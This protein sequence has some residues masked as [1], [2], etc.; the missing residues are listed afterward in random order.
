M[1]APDRSRVT[2]TPRT[3]TLR[4]KH[5]STTVL[6][7]VEPLQKLPEVKTELLI[8]L[9]ETHPSGQ[10]NGYTIPKNVDYVQLGRAVDRNNLKL[11]YVS[12]D[13]QEENGETPGKGKGKVA[14][15]ATTKAAA[16]QLK[17]C[18]Q[19]AGFRNGDVVAFR[20]SDP[21]EEQDAGADKWDVVIP[22]LEDTYG[23]EEQRDEGFEE[24]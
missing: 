4:F 23:D 3:W 5:H 24:G 15:N 7:E 2:P 20:F 22:T 11:G 10:I 12:I 16:S 8:A 18:P 21:S 1:Y 19:G 17:D 9:T 14:A 6:L 13:K